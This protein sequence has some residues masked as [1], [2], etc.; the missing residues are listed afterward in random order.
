MEVKF[1]EVLGQV[2]CSPH[3]PLH[4]NARGDV[5][6]HRCSAHGLKVDL[7]PVVVGLQQHLGLLGPDAAVVCE[8]VLNSSCLGNRSDYQ[9]F[10]C[11]LAGQ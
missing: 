3:Q 8:K 2:S 9:R 6:Q 11:I 1:D 5:P 10:L 4:D 7:L